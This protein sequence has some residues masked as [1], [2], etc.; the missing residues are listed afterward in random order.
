MSAT[1]KLQEKEGIP[2]DH[3]RLI[4]AGKEV[5]NITLSKLVSLSLQS[6]R[7]QVPDPVVVNG[8]SGSERGAHR[9]NLYVVASHKRSIFNASTRD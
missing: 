5:R 2:L 8:S 7:L 3:I 9:V 1:E 4:F 6:I